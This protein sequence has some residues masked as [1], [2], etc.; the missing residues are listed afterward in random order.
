MKKIATTLSLILALNSNL[1]ANDSLKKFRQG[2]YKSAKNG[3]LKLVK[4]KNKY[5][6]YYYGLMELHG[7]TI[8][9]QI[10]FG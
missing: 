1:Y 2:D 10:A 9:T 8:K 7:Y 4:A 5:A 6:L 3:L